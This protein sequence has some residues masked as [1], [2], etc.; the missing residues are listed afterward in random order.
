MGEGGDAEDNVGNSDV[1]DY[2]VLNL[3]RFELGCMRFYV[4]LMFHLFYD[5][6][7]HYTAS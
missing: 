4:I 1:T 2:D 5:V 3:V 7:S 6:L